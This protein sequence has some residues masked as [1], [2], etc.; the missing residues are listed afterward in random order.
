MKRALAVAVLIL[1][2]PAGV[3]AATPT[4]SA[5]IDGTKGNG[6]WYV[7]SVVIRWHV[8]SDAT[9]SDCQAAI[10]VPDDT[11]GTTKSCSASNS[12]GT[13]NASV[14]VKI[15]KTPPVA[16]VA[17]FARSPDSGPWFNHAVGVTWSGSDALSG[18]AGCTAT[19]YSGPDNPAA[20][21]SGTCTD[22]AGNVSAPLG[23]TLAYD[24]TPP[25]LDGVTATASE[26]AIA[27]RWSAS[28]DTVSVRVDRSPGRAGA[29]SSPV[30]Q[31]TGNAVDDDALLGGTR[32]T[33]T[34]TAL[35]AAGNAATATASAVPTGTL[36]APAP[37][38]KLS[39]PPMLR[40]KPIKGARY[41]N[42]QLFRGKA[43]LLSA[44]PTKAHYQLRSAW[45][46]R[47]HKHRLLPGKYRW[48]VWPGYGP[49]KHH[50]YGKLLGR[51]TFTQG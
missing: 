2:F 13:A 47:G 9:S 18:I 14:T 35:D 39:R 26:A 1:A 32:Y 49:R 38:A 41:Y 12:D 40:W 45:T 43:K 15:D 28:P 37:G 17:A 22:K 19:T 3:R 44:W 33:Y 20:S 11:A 4:I 46:Y 50:R 25:A 48:Y 34:L 29:P 23:T 30:Y 31:G 36:L 51:R 8:S 24:A 42:V 16:G 21:L 6:G 5:T 7:S 27:L 10:S